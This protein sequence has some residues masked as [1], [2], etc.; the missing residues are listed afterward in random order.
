M[1][2]VGAA[3]AWPIWTM[4]KGVRWGAAGLLWIGGFAAFGWGFGIAFFGDPA[5]WKG[6]AAFALWAVSTVMIGAAVRLAGFW[7]I[8]KGGT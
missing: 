6:A 5:A 4:T 3:R 2:L 7:I 1:R 8:N